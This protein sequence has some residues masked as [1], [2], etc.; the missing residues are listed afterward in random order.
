M[1]DSKVTMS[2][3][4]RAAVP[5][6]LNAG[7]QSKNRGPHS[8]VVNQSGNILNFDM[9]ILRDDI[10]HRINAGFNLYTL[11][12]CRTFLIEIIRQTTLWEEEE[13]A[14]LQYLAE[15]HTKVLPGR[16]VVY[17]WPPCATQTIPFCAPHDQLQ[18]NPLYKVTKV[19]EELNRSIV[20]QIDQIW[21]DRRERLLLAARILRDLEEAVKVE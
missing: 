7:T 10:L 1:N 20:R 2:G 21:N 12:E 17:Q 15:L 19:V 16:Q 8:W 14:N 5:A 13:L 4:Y 6:K 3:S 11:E 18:E 9:K